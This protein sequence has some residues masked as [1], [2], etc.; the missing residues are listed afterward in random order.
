MVVV[1]LPLLLL[2][3]RPHGT[4][5]TGHQRSALTQ[6][7]PAPG[8]LRANTGPLYPLL[9]LVTLQRLLSCPQFPEP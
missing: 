3:L 6:W 5:A 7:H 9:M 4:M 8:V 1:P 2:L